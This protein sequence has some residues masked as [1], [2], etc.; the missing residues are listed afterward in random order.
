LQE[1]GL[2]R[3]PA[4]CNGPNR[5][6]CNGQQAHLTTCS[7][8]ACNERL[9]N[10]RTTHKME[11]NCA[12]THAVHAHTHTRTHT[13]ARTHGHTRARA[14]TH[15]QHN[16]HHTDKCT[17]ARAHTHTLTHSLLH[18]HART[19]LSNRTGSRCVGTSL[20]VLRMDTC[21]AA[22]PTCHGVFVLDGARAI[23]LGDPRVPRNERN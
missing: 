6:T 16:T 20:C 10:M 13:R 3:Q 19:H 2:Q 14:H 11:L 12:R 8:S 17:R 7:Q 1:F 22:M 15:R 9:C 4:T 18:T 21:E 23:L 5:Q